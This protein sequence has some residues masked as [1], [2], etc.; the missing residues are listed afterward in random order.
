MKRVLLWLVAVVLVWHGAVLGVQHRG[1]AAAAGGAGGM[2]K[3]DLDLLDRFAGQMLMGVYAS[4]SHA[5]IVQ[6]MLGESRMQEMGLS[7]TQIGEVAQ[8]RI[9]EMCYQ[10]ALHMLV[11]RA[12]HA[13][14]GTKP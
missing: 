7:A 8:A 2:T 11:A 5:R 6:E 12:E 13:K 1:R 4:E 14:E 9:A 10:Q 3:T